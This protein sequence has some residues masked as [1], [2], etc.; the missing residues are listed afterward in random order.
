VGAEPEAKRTGFAFGAQQRNVKSIHGEAAMN[1]SPMNG[2]PTDLDQVIAEI[3]NL[4]A[5]SPRV[6]KIEAPS[7]APF[8]QQAHDLL[9]RSIDQVASDWVHQLARV[10]ENSERVEEIVLQRVSAVKAQITALYVLGGAAMAEA[11]RGDDVNH[12]LA[13]ELDKLTVDAA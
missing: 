12:K 3:K 4:A 6:Q 9:L 1:G 2:H 10:R 5:A 13:S 7:Q 8:G 11:Q